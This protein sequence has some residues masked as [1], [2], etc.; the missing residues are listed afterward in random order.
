MKRLV[1][2]LW[3]VWTILAVVCAGFALIYRGRV[4]M[5]MACAAVLTDL[6]FGLICCIVIRRGASGKE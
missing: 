6:L 4:Y 5:L 3:I 1:L 2:V